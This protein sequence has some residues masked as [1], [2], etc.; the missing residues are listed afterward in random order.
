[1]KNLIEINEVLRNSNS[2]NKLFDAE[3][4]LEKNKQTEIKIENNNEI[5]DNELENDNLK[6]EN[7][8]LYSIK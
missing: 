8:N 5:N 7:N 3:C 6:D 1:M 2:G 4:V